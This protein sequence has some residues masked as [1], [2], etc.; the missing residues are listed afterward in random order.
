MKRYTQSVDYETRMEEA[1]FGGWV[2]WIDIEALIKERDE[3]RTQAL[4]AV[5]LLPTD[6]EVNDLRRLRMEAIDV[7]MGEDKKTIAK[8]QDDLN[9]WKEAFTAAVRPPRPGVNA[10]YGTKE[11]RGKVGDLRYAL[12]ITSLQHAPNGGLEIEVQLP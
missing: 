1:S 4:A 10:V 7:F 11:G 9:Y 8:L 2:R 5:W 12:M 6:I 3:L